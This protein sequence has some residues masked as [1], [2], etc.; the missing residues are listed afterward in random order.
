MQ[1]NENDKKLKMPGAQGE[2]E[3][4]RYHQI[5]KL[6]V[7]FMNVVI[8]R[9]YGIFSSLLCTIGPNSFHYPIYSYTHLYISIIRMI[10]IY[11]EENRKREGKL[12]R[13]LLI[14]SC[15]GT[16]VCNIHRYHTVNP[17]DV[18]FKYYNGF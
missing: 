8:A 2:G 7:L 3:G 6:L 5:E 9:A 12:K 1:K 14:S 15:L 17:S 11:R 18:S 4:L 13:P 10:D 16:L